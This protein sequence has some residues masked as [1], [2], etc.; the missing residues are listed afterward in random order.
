MPTKQVTRQSIAALATISVSVEPETE[1]FVGNC[2]AIDQITDRQNEEYIAAQL[3]AGNEWAWCVVT[4][5]AT[6]NE[7]VGI[8]VLG[9]C[10]YASKT[11]FDEFEREHMVSEALDHLWS[12]I[13]PLAPAKR[14]AQ[15]YRQAI[16]TSYRGPT[17]ARGSRIIARCEAKRIAWECD[18]RLSIQENHAAAALHLMGILGWGEK[19]DLVMGGTG[20]GCVFVQVPKGGR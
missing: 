12:Q 8:A 7:Y 15:S 14:M 1:S 18:D 16:T 6:L 20:G 9:G 4:V 10:S 17:D 11:A 3:R 19:N 13:D 5:R 2:S